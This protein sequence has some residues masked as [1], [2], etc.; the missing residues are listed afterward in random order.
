MLVH[1]SRRVKQRQIESSRSRLLETLTGSRDVTFVRSVGN[2]GD[3]LIWAGTRRLLAGVSHREVGIGELDG[4]SGHT[5]LLSGGGAWSQPYHELLP[6]VLGALDASFERVV[7]LP[8][9]FDLEVP[10]VRRALAR[11]RAL[12]F[13]REPVSYRLISQVCRAQLA[14]DC[15]FFFDFASYRRG[16]YGE[17]TA[18][19][20]DRESPLWGEVYLVDSG[21][22][23]RLLAA[24]VEGSHDAP[25]P[26]PEAHCRFRLYSG[27]R[28]ERCIAEVAVGAD[29]P[30]FGIQAE[31]GTLLE[32]SP[33]N[34]RA[35]VRWRVKRG[36]PSDNVDISAQS[37][38][39]DA[40]LWTIARHERIR[41]DRAHVMIAAAMLDK[42]V[43]VRP[44][45]TH[46]VPAIA[47][48]NFNADMSAG[49]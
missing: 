39:L 12:V 33:G 14:C 28:R 31:D 8:S 32:V 1:G 18:H 30:D 6:D 10:S 21:G 13:A 42:T 37:P 26:A 46:K 23:E 4:V 49:S 7:V 45:S 27:T 38:S 40:W 20:A 5:V 48:W 16:G 19:R 9:S 47:R 15:A 36:L 24:G 3:E 17:L 35:I 25:W 44:S 43:E 29:R 41:T 34:A 2:V 11:T 22:E